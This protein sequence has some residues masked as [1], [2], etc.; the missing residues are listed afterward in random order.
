MLLDTR[1]E[2]AQRQ[3]QAGLAFLRAYTPRSA[4]HAESKCPRVLLTG[5]TR[6][7]NNLDNPTGRIV[8]QLSG[9]TYPTSSVPQ[10]NEIDDPAALTSVATRQ[11]VVTGIGEVTLCG[12]I[13][14]VQWDIAPVL[15][16][17][18]IEAFKP[19]LVLMNGVAAGRV[20]IPLRLE[21]GSANC[22]VAKV[23]GSAITQP[24]GPYA[25]TTWGPAISLLENGPAVAPGRLSWDAVQRGVERELD[26]LARAGD[27][28]TQTIT[29]VVRGMFPS[30]WL[31]YLCNNLAYT[32]NYLMDN[33]DVV[34]RLYQSSAAVGSAVNG[35]E[36]GLTADFRDVPRTFVHW[37]D[38][39]AGEYKSA[40][41]VALAI[42]EAQLVAYAMHDSAAYGRASMA[43]SRDD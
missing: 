28:L 16:A 40:A 8:E 2:L 43:T 25:D 42:I 35:V 11:I 30:R 31:T 5:F 23:D 27:P 37:P 26:R 21:L 3:Y 34:L 13:L 15:V 17:K 10:P 7:G 6:F 1:A 41:R 9:A 33:P 39:P 12:M 36:V 18:E 24:A 22:A 38:V 29:G 20:G 14:P 32:I 19:D 4:S